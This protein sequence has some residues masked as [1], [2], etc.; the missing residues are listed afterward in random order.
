MKKAILIVTC[1]VILISGMLLTECKRVEIGS[2]SGP[3][4]TRSYDFIDFTSIEIGY[5]FKLEV[6]PAD[7]YSIKIDASESLLDHIKV[8]KTGIKLEIGID[9]LFFT[10]T[11]RPE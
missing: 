11:G 10:S 8:T 3:T 4:V 5:A 7:T 1:A 6:I 2:E 9:R